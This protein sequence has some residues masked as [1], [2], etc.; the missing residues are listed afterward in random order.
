MENLEMYYNLVEGCIGRLGVD[1]TICRGEK[2]G[3][4]SLKKG[5]VNVWIDVFHIEKEKRAYFQVMSQVMNIPPTNKEALYEE[6]LT[7]NDRLFGVAFTIY[8]NIVWLKVIRET[9][10]LDADEAFAMI[11][12]IGNY[13]DD[14]DDKLKAKYP[15]PDLPDSN[16][17]PGSPPQS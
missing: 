15:S 4:W 6:L 3:Q 8:K 16:I 17:N 7:L 12:R 5:S 13:A 14:Y 1:P 10:G 9:Q 2:P 11:T